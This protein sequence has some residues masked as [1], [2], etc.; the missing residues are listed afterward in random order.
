MGNTTVFLGIEDAFRS[1][2]PR[3]AG[4]VLPVSRV[5]SDRHSI[6]MEAEAT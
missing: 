4:N 3:A 1:A 6:W 2:V 5:S